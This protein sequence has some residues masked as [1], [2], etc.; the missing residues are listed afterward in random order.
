MFN[1]TLHNYNYYYYYHNYY[2][3][4]KS[5]KTPAATSAPP[6]IEENSSGFHIVEIHMPTVGSGLGLMVVIILL[7]VVFIYLY[8]KMKK[9]CANAVHQRRQQLQPGQDMNTMSPMGLVPYQGPPISPYH[10]QQ[11]QQH[12]QHAYR[13]RQENRF[14]D[15]SDLEDD[16]VANPT[17]YSAREHRA[18]RL[19]ISR[20]NNTRDRERDEERDEESDARNSTSCA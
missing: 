11:L 17:R 13:P 18:T 15:I 19:L 14:Q 8:T 7:V 2:N 10:I 1:S 3:M 6:T 16:I 9:R 5:S 20:S 4:C 12:L